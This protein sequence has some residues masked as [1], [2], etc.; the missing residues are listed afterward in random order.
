MKC[1][2]VGCYARLFILFD[3]YRDGLDG[4]AMSQGLPD[5]DGKNGSQNR[6]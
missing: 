1:L 6:Y 5:E 2:R 4:T 3:F